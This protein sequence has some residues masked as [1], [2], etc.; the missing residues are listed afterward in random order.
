MPKGHFMMVPGGAEIVDPVVSEAQRRAMHAASRGKSQLGI[1]RK[2]GKEFIAA[3]HGVRNLP[4][5]V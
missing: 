1:S 3:S 5:R 2:V 4:E